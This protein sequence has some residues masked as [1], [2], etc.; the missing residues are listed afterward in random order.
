MFIKFEYFNYG[1]RNSPGKGAT[2]VARST[3]ALIK[4]INIGLLS[5]CR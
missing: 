1:G 3:N 5:Q 4:I 2:I